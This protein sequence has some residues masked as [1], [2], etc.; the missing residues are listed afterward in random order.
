MRSSQRVRLFD[1]QERP[2]QAFM[3]VPVDLEGRVL[4][5]VGGHGLCRQYKS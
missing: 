5:D 4:D 2:F 1:S 3:L